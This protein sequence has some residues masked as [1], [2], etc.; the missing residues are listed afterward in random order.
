ML[1]TAVLTG[2]DMKEQRVIVQLAKDRN[3]TPSLAGDGFALVIGTH[4][5][6]AAVVREVHWLA[7]EAGVSLTAYMIAPIKPWISALIT[8]QAEQIR[9]L[10]TRLDVSIFSWDSPVRNFATF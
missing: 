4:N 9:R 6:D 2:T 5:L 8:P 3:E 10:A 7:K 1:V